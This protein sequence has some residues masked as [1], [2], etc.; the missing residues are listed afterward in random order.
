MRYNKLDLVYREESSRAR[1]FA[2][3]K[4]QVFSS[5][6]DGLLAVCI[7]NGVVCS[8]PIESEPVKHFWVDVDFW[9]AMDS[10]LRDL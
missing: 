6:A 3:T 8:Q 7:F 9:I 5:D 4:C 1:I 2:V 10:L